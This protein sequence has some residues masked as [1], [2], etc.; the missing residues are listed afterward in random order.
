MD[1]GRMTTVST[2]G[3]Q[4]KRDDE[5]LAEFFVDAQLRGLTEGTIGT[6]RSQ[7]QYFLDWT[8]TSL[9]A[10]GRDE[11]K[12]FLAH[13]K[14]ERKAMDGSTGLTPS[15]L[16]SY[17]SALNSLFKFLRYEG[18][19]QENPVP[20][21]RER[22]IDS[23]S[24][25]PTSRR[26]LISVEQVATLVFS[27]LNPRNRAIIVLLD[28]TGIR[29]KELIQ[30]NLADID[31]EQQSIQLKPTPK[32]TNT[33]VLFNGECARVLQRWLR[34][35]AESEPETDALFINQYG[36]RLERTGVY[37]VVT[38]HA[39]PIGFHN[40]DA[41][42]NQKKFTP[43]CCRHWFTTHLQR[44]N[45]PREFIQ[46]LRGDTRKDAIDIY[47]HIDREELREAYLAHIPTLGI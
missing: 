2:S 28:K 42:D 13:L 47:D 16:N 17:F 3:D 40:P 18:Y 11:F 15:T 25:S 33:L 45:M 14:H 46:E 19:I 31:W 12:R 35:R 8:E 21:F 10:V 27:V 30:I 1:V 39:K 22:H 34:T 41:S 26:Q 44:T 4:P 24:T 32:R 20:L 37:K 38:K 43:H 9:T 29:R 7:L 6:Y 36:E 5:L 23:L